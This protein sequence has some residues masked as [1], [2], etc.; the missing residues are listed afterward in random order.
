M[1]RQAGRRRR[2][3]GR[4]RG[5]RQAGRR[6]P[7]QE[8]RHELGGVDVGH[9][10]LG[11]DVQLPAEGRAEEQL[12]LLGL[13]LGL[14]LGGRRGGPRAGAARLDVRLIPAVGS[15]VAATAAAAA[16]G[17]HLVAAPQASA[18]PKRLPASGR[19]GGAGGGTDS[20]LAPPIP[21][22]PRR[23]AQYGLPQL[24]YSL[25]ARSPAAILVVVSPLV[26]RPSAWAGG[27]GRTT[28]PV[29]PCARGFSLPP[30]WDGRC[31]S[32]EPPRAEELL[33]PGSLAL[34]WWALSSL[35]PAPPRGETGNG[36]GASHVGGLKR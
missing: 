12:L 32:R 8:G 33:L 16:V 19:E 35:L 26:A 2:Q 25:A 15:R 18:A 31:S 29:G 5:R 20:A 22:V 28:L 27:G 34:A 1:G 9:E 24:P 13:G 3:A 4:G 7:A 36:V 10:G 11:V 17:L 14:S 30:R 23:P 6:P 21:R